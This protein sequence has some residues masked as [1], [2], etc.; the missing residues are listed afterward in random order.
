MLA[1]IMCPFQLF[2]GGMSAGLSAFGYWGSAI[3]LTWYTG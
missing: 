2:F 1:V 3:T